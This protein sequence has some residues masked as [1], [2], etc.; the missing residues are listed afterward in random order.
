MEAIKPV[1]LKDTV[2]MMDSTDYKER[3][4]AE[5]IQGGYPVSKAEMHA[6]QMGQGK[7]KLLSNLPEK[8]L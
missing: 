5:Y 7:A 6:C 8:H 4:K 1:E 2:S 3:F